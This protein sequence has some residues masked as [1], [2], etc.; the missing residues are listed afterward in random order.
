[1]NT[2]TDLMLSVRIRW[3]RLNQDKIKTH[4]GVD[5]LVILGENDN[6]WDCW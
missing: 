6:L 3:I 5:P 2:K 1:M 4:I